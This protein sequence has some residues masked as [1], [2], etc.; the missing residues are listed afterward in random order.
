[1]QRLNLCCL[2]RN[3]HKFG[4]LKNKDIWNYEEFSIF[5]SMSIVS[6]KK[7]FLGIMSD[8]KKKTRK[9]RKKLNEK[10]TEIGYF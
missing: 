8:I 7:M 3:H 6:F 9:K 5:A 4:G 10:V 2:L 1:M